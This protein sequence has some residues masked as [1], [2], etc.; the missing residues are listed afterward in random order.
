[1]IR[2]GV[3]G[4]GYWSGPWTRVLQDSDE[5]ELAAI[6]DT[7]AARQAR[8]HRRFPDATDSLAGMDA[9]VVLTPVSA[10]YEVARTALL[11]GQHVMCA[12]PLASSLGEAE[13]LVALAAAREL[14]LATDH[15]FVYTGAVREAK[16]LY[17]G[18]T[19]GSLLY[20]DSVR[21][22]LGL[23]QPDVDVLWD[24]AAHD[25]SIFNHLLGCGPDIVAATGSDP[26]GRGK[27]SG[28]HLNLWYGNLLA[29]VHV[30]WLSPV[31]VRRT[32]IAGDARMIVYDDMEPTEKIKLY[33]SGAM[34]REGAL[35]DYRSGDMLAPKLD[36]TEALAVECR[37]FAACIRG[38][39]V[40]VSGGVEGVAVVRVLEA[41][42]E[43]LAAAGQRVTLA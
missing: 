31:K 18:G 5:F 39:T 11:M 12:K 21:V 35:M 34:P 4:A 25:I 30:N 8:A 14:V 38:E 40:P 19:L 36:F 1:M 22:N 28:A 20:L 29:H 3:A 37:H 26:L 24:L 23:F 9:V 7:D 10:H 15:T 43:S 6:V 13:D 33:D 2:V 27:V 42:S 32:L 16:R 41:A 17:D